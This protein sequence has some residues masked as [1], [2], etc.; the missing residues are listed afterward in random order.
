H[1][2]ADAAAAVAA[3]PPV[4]VLFAA[5]LGYNPIEH[6]LGP[7]VIAQVPPAD[8][9]ALTGN[10]FFPTLISGPFEAGLHIA[11]GFAIA[12]CLVAAVSSLARGSRYVAVEPPS[13]KPTAE[14][15]RLHHGLS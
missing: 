14:P 6:L 5:F 12:A 10:T 13:P 7:A 1:V 2:P 8:T 4:S 15:T 9:A 11:F 3:S